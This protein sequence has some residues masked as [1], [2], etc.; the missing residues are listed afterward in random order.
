M[1]SKLE[2]LRIRGNRLQGMI[3]DVHKD[4]DCP[5]TLKPYWGVYCCERC[6]HLVELMHQ[7]VYLRMPRYFQLYA[8]IDWAIRGYLIYPIQDAYY[9]ILAKVT[10][11]N[12]AQGN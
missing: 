7:D 5:E 8:N 9:W 12:N 2:L 6:K 3:D 1:A 11:K 10:P 4:E